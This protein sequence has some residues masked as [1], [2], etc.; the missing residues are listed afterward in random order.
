[1]G[2]NLVEDP[3]MNQENPEMGPV[4]PENPEM[5]AAIPENPRMEAA[6]PETSGTGE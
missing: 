3:E 2:R 4:S 6:I 5:G 1:L